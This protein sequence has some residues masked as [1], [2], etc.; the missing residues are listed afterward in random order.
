MR[1][2]GNVVFD[3]STKVDIREVSFI[4]DRAGFKMH[5]VR[6]GHLE[7][8]ELFEQCYPH[9][10]PERDG[11]VAL[12]EVCRVACIKKFFPGQDEAYKISLQKATTGARKKENAR[13]K[14]E[15]KSLESLS[16]SA[17]KKPKGKG[18][19]RK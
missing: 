19:G 1:D 7:M 8:A 15:A 14:G 10:V 4:L 2:E 17:P 5:G 3:M 6:L 13:V 11:K 18:R 12:T 9:G 16:A